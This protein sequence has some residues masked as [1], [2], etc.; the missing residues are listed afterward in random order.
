M[1]RFTSEKGRIPYVAP[2][3]R[4]FFPNSSFFFSVFLPIASYDKPASSQKREKKKTRILRQM[5]KP[6]GLL[7]RT[8]THFESAPGIII[9]S[10]NRL[11]S[12]YPEHLDQ[13]VC[14]CVNGEHAAWS[15]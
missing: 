10:L 14:V 11:G 5:S 1:S 15:Q 8:I 4:A 9:I 12:A 2:T 3:A 7:K 6:S 13:V